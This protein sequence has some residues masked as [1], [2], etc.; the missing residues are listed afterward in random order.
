M[1]Y[2]VVQ[3]SI[4]TLHLDLLISTRQAYSGTPGR[5]LKVLYIGIDPL[6]GLVRESPP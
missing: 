1:A 5:V 3:P 2:I 6:Y 4:I